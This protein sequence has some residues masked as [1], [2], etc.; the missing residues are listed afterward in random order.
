MGIFFTQQV[1]MSVLAYTV[2]LDKLKKCMFSF[3]SC[4]CSNFIV[5]E[6]QKLFFKRWWHL[7]A[8]ID[9]Y[10]HLYK[11]V[12]HQLSYFVDVDGVDLSRDLQG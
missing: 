12:R 3:Q 1:G 8:F 5:S 10:T 4:F 7:V 6:T 9:H 11:I 2:C